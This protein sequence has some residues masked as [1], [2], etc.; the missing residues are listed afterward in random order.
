MTGWA[1]YEG[2][3]EDRLVRVG[4]V[5]YRGFETRFGVGKKRC[6][7]VAAVVGGKEGKRSD[8]KCR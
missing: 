5:K 7:Q 4:E 1:V 8:V 6:V 3:E 2:P